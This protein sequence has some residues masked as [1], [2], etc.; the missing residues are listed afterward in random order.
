[1]KYVKRVLA[2]VLVL[3][4][5]LSLSGC[6][7]FETKM[8]KASSKMKKVDNLRADVHHGYGFRHHRNL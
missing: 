3:V 1:M 2:V 7:A 8:A 4:L 5:V 6:T